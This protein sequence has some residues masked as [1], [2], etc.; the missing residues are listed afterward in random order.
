MFV[1]HSNPWNF[2]TLQ[3]HILLFV[4]AVQGQNKMQFKKK[5]KDI[6][7][8]ARSLESLINSSKH[9]ASRTIFSLMS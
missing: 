4:A 5:K 6:C 9:M 3:M 7:T 1:S 2:L 8:M